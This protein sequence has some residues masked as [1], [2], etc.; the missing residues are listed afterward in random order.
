MAARARLASIDLVSDVLSAVESI[1]LSTRQIYLWAAVA[2]AAG[3][4]LLVL[5]LKLSRIV[6]ALGG[7]ALGFAVAPWVAHRIGTYRGGGTA[8]RVTQGVMAFCMAI[9]AI[10]D[11]RLLWALAAAIAGVAVP[12]A[13]M[14]TTPIQITAKAP[15]AGSWAANVFHE[16]T[17]WCQDAWLYVHSFATAFVGQYGAGAA[18]AIPSCGL[19]VLVLALIFSK[20]ARIA[21]TSLLGSAALTGGALLLVRQHHRR[22][23]DQAK[24]N[25]LYVVGIVAALA[26]VGMVVQR[27][28]NRPRTKTKQPDRPLRPAPPPPMGPT[29][30]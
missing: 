8:F 18:M 1:P 29:T 23:W 22:L 27:L 16:L 12:M 28:L 17:P 30:H 2:V 19:A 11:A 25:S 3:I 24:G 15:A 26:V 14:V 13:A 21:M 9:L 7:A 4:V 6:V 5:G 10:V 20:P